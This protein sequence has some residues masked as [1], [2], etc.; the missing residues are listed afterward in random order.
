MQTVTTAFSAEERDLIRS[1][2]H[3]FQVSWKK[4]TTLGN[5]TFTIGVSLI[6]GNDVIGI[7]PG[8]VGSPGNYKYFDESQYVTSLGWDRG[9]TM[10]LGGLAKGMAEATLDNT[11]GRFTPRFMGGN[12]EL[13]TAVLPRRP[14]IINAGFNVGGVDIT[15]PQFAG[16]FSKQPSVNIRSGEVG[17]S[18]ADYIDFFQN[19][20]LDVDIMFT[21][22][23]TDQVLESAFQTLGFS[24]AQYSLD[25]GL[26]TIPFGLFEKGTKFS[27]L[28]HQ[29]VEAENGNV[30][31]DESGIVRFENRQHWDT[32]PYDSV[33]K[34]ISTA[35][36]LSQEVPNTD[37]I[38]NVVEVKTDILEKQ[39]TD[40]L[41]K[42]GSPVPLNAT[43]ATELFVSFENPVV[44]LDAV[45]FYVANSAADE[46]GSDITSN[47][48]VSRTDK[49]ARSVKIT[50]NNSGAAGYLTQLTLYGREVRKTSDLYVRT[51]NDSSVTAYE[52]QP[53]TINNPYIQN[54]FWAESLAG[55]LV[56][57]FGEPE[58]IQKIT[59]RAMPS[60]QL[61]DLVSWQGHYWRIY[62][63]K[64]RLSKSE[65]FTTELTMLQRQSRTYF[66][67]GIS[68][69]GG[70]DR[71]AP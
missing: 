42:L 30:Y 61:G 18:M 64:S 22:Q 21:S 71:I 34:V 58:N 13:Y 45:Q 37:H 3:N 60:L 32:A 5:R 8:A 15:I 66:R 48:T 25:Q 14:A 47:I 6:G 7:N 69:I 17:I 4:Q 2:A 49:F 63:M 35:Q 12:S 1:I 27:D 56:E 59:V 65:G 40:Q 19:K 44:F 38:I 9:L 20:Y 53:I 46:S 36:V 57:E 55:L 68:T 62:D 29:V 33:V 28:V 26:T 70:T 41:F 10:P 31:Q 52:E 50:F 24:T 16:T 67:I 51:K 54:K 23:R 39:P 43:G 11:S